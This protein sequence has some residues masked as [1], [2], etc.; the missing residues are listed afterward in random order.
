MSGAARLIAEVVGVYEGSNGDATKA[1]YARLEALGPI[2]IIA[3]NLFRAQKTS[4]RAK[5]Y[6]RSAHRHRSYDTKQWS[7]G[8][9]AR[10]L[11]DHAAQVG[12]TWGWAIDLEQAHHN[13]VLYV[14]IP[15]GQVSFHTDTKGI[16]PDYHGHWDGMRDVAADRICRWCARLLATEAERERLI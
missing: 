12:I 2:G 16:G 13:A 14:D 9:L 8:N 3:T 11:T 4:S 7:M 6:R 1:F 10:A 15:T 5:V